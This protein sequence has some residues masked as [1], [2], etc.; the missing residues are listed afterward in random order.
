M[1]LQAS[2]GKQ[3]N[4]LIGNGSVKEPQRRTD[5]QNTLNLVK[6]V[7]SFLKE[8][9]SLQKAMFVSDNVPSLTQ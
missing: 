9:R 5:G 3:H 7:W 6:E 1:T 4:I 2:M 8:K